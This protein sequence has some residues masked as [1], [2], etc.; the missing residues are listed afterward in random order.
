MDATDLIGETAAAVTCARQALGGTASA[1]VMFN[2]IL[3]RL[4]LDSEGLGEA[5]T[6]SL[7]D[8]ATAGFHNYGESWL[9]HVNQ[10]LTG[11]MFG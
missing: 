8:T 7:G 3:R 9:G 4:E 11:V 10:T 2:C 5:F 1:S 6:A